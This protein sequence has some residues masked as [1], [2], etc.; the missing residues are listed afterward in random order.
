MLDCASDF[1]TRQGKRC[2]LRLTVYVLI[3]RSKQ[4]FN[5]NPQYL[6]RCESCMPQTDNDRAK[7]FFFVQAEFITL[8]H[9]TK[10]LTQQMSKYVRENSSKNEI[11]VKHHRADSMEVPNRTASISFT[12]FLS[13][14]FSFCK[15]M[16][17][18]Q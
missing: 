16:T 2:R 10:F 6:L 3:I 18:Y 4:N 13:A 9:S 17:V 11:A 1:D 5:Q 8:K 7:H 15:D 12:I 14:L